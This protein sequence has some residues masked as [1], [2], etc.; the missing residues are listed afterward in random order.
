[1]FNRRDAGGRITP[2]EG[3]LGV[4]GGAPAVFDCVAVGCLRSKFIFQTGHDR[5]S[6][7]LF[8]LLFRSFSFITTLV[9][10]FSF[11]TTLVNGFSFITAFFTIIFTQF[12]F[13]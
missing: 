13:F 4:G 6:A 12:A 8:I 10:I 2:I 11:I 7:S 1:M 9:R 5:S 3:R